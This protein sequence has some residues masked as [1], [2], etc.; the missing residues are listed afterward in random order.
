MVATLLISALL[1]HPRLDAWDIK[2]NFEVGKKQSWQISL[3]ANVGG[4]DIDA[5]F[6]HTINPGEAAADGTRKLG[7]TWE[8]IEVQGQANPNPEPFELK[9]GAD[10]TVQKAITPNDDDYRRCLSV[11]SFIYPTKPVSV[12]DKW[13]SELPADG[14]AKKVKFEYEATELTKI[15][16]V[17]VLK[18]KGKQTED[19]ADGITSDGEWWVAKDGSVLKYKLQVKNWA[20]PFAGTPPMEATITGEKK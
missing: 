20:V 8:N 5:K 13:T 12:G 1:A 14:A 4:T 2:P 17:E 7:V 11:F 3:A 9:I 18:M 6:T 16:E 19:G 10:G 15:G